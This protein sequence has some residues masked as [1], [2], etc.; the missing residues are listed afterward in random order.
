MKKTIFLLGIFTLLACE[1]VDKTISDSLKG[2]TWKLVGFVDVKIDIIKE[3]EPKSDK[4]YVIKFN[5]DNTLS[6]ISST[7]QITGHYIVNSDSLKI[8]IDMHTV[9]EINE[10]YDGNS[11]LMTINSV[12]NFSF[13]EKTLK[14]YYNEGNNYLLFKALE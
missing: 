1:D 13:E 6:G 5:E 9:T 11:Y 10:L 2:T 7:N 12:H 3:A 4:C 8:T 14:L